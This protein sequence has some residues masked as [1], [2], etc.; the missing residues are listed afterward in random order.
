MF[1]DLGL[2]FWIFILIYVVKIVRL[3]QLKVLNKFW[4]YVN[5]KMYK[6]AA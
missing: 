3:L 2:D 5:I 4:L 6:N 1:L